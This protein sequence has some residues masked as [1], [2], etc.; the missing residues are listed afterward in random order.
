MSQCC[1]FTRDKFIWVDETG[2]DARDHIC[3]Y[4][5]AI[6]G[7]KPVSHRSLSRGQRINAYSGIYSLSSTGIMAVDIVTSTVK[8]EEF[9]DF[10]WGSLI[11]RMV[12]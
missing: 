12:D 4:G 1:L 6:R 7:C 3:R 2:S 5:H 10:L 9:F 8:G 11:P